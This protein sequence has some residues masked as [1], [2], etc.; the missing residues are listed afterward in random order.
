MLREVPGAE[1]VCHRRTALGRRW[2]L[3]VGTRTSAAE[4]RTPAVRALLAAAQ[5]EPVLVVD[6]GAGRYW[7]FEERFYREA[8]G[9]SADDVLALVREREA[10]DRRRLERAH[11][12]AA[13]E[14]APPPG[15]REPIPR[16]VR[17]AVFERDGGACVE[18]GSR[19][20]LQ[21]DHVIPVSLGGAGT[22]ENLQVL[23]GDCNRRKGAAVG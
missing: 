19:F 5:A 10:R 20:E 23:C 7:L 9:L 13:R 15:R 11:A 8:S 1:I 2:R 4:W 21:F 22:A 12:A 6:D 14:G 17:V 3:Q 16:A 18:C